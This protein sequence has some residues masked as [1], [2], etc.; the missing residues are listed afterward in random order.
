MCD[1]PLKMSDCVLENELPVYLIVPAAGQ[2]TRMGSRKN[3]PFIDLQGTPVIIR[4]LL[5]LSAC[6]CVRGMIVVAREDEVPAMEMLFAQWQIER[7]LTVI[8]GGLTRQDSVFAG[9]K[10]LA[11]LLS[12]LPGVRSADP[13]VA[14]H[15]GARCLVTQDVICRTLRHAGS[16]APCAAAVPVKDTIKVADASGRVKVTLDRSVLFAIQTPQAA[17]LSELLA[18]FEKAQ[19]SDF[20]ATDDLSVLEAAGVAVDLV[21]GDETNIKLTTPYDLMI[22]QALLESGRIQDGSPEPAP[23]CRIL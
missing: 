10:A 6:P 22:A 9:I 16:V 21:P 1:C 11:D 2:G 7:L 3:K 23:A 20:S 14:I 15:D 8:P 5:T 17:R 4:T 13:V 19:E 18:A 12:G